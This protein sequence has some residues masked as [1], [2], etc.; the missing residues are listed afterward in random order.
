MPNCKII[1]V[2]PIGSKLADPNSESSSF[3]MEGIGKDFTP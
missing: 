3:L 1:G 2:D